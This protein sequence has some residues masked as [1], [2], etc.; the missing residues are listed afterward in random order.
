MRSIAAVL[1]VLAVGCG[2]GKP[3]SSPSPSATVATASPSP[4]ASP[5]ASAPVRTTPPRI[6]VIVMENKEYG[7]VIGNSEAPYTNSLARRYALATN[8]LA[9]A[10]PSLPNYLALI[11]GDTFGIASDCTDCYVAKK[12]LVDGLEGAKL[13]WKAFMEGMPSPC[14]AGGSAGRYAKKHNP[15]A[16][17]NSIRLSPSRCRNVVPFTAFDAKK[18]PAFT[19]I[20]PDLCSD[21]HDCPVATGDAWLKRVVPGIL[22]NLGPGGVLFLTYDEGGSALGGGGHIVT[23][24][25]GDGVRPGTYDSPYNHY[26]LLRTIQMRYGIAPVGKA[27][28]ATAMSEMLRPRPDRTR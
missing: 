13:T 25:A 27:A 8:Y 20:T 3:S 24:A 18:L 2:T 16:Y 28:Q 4:S 22:T 5:S 6:A 9:V 19:W 21:T 7:R 14:F 1:L 12:N 10:H 15:F 23:I 26:S 11:G 17:F